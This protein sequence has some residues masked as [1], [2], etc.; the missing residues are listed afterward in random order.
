MGRVEWELI[1]IVLL[2]LTSRVD[3]PIDSMALHSITEE[4]VQQITPW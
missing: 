3:L 2:E 1:M 4:G